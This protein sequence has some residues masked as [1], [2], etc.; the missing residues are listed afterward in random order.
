MLVTFGLSELLNSALVAQNKPQVIK[1][2][3]E[4]QAVAGLIYGPQYTTR[5]TLYRGET[6]ETRNKYKKIRKP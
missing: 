4:K 3:L 2:Y 6:K 5:P 1:L